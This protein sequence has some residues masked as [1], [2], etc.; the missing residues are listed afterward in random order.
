MPKPADPTLSPTAKPND[1]LCKLIHLTMFQRSTYIPI[2]IH[3]VN[4][5]YPM[6]VKALIDTGVTGQFIDVEYVRMNFRPIVSPTCLQSIM[7][8]EPQM[9]QAILLKLSTLLF[10]IKTT[11]IN[12]PFMSRVSAK[13]QSFWDTPG[14]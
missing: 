7:W 10:P 9:K 12:P 1:S 11:W 3:T 8:M 13:V 4:S 5:N 6:V 14:L 2:H